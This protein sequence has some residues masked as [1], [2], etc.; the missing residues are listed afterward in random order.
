MEVE[1]GRHDAVYTDHQLHK[2]TQAKGYM[3]VTD[4]IRNP[5]QHQQEES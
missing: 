5:T 3:A 4:G 1:Q 2:E